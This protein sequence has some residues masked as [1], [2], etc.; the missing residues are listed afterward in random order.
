[1]PS[2]FILEKLR[3]GSF[4]ENNDGVRQQLIQVLKPGIYLDENFY[5]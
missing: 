5:M 3:K 2:Y 4:L 1:M